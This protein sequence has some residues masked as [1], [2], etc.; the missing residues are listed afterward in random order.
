MVESCQ[1]ETNRL[2]F[3]LMCCRMQ[4]DK[5]AFVGILQKLQV[6]VSN[7]INSS[8]IKVPKGRIGLTLSCAIFSCYHKTLYTSA[9]FWLSNHFS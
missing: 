7:R 9:S 1:E 6:I 2:E 5:Y 4:I 8:I 3:V